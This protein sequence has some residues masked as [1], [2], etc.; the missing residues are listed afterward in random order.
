VSLFTVLLLTTAALFSGR[1]E[2]M[3]DRIQIALDRWGSRKSAAITMR[4]TPQRLS[5]A[6]RG[7]SP[8][9][10]FRLAELPD[11]FHDELDAL[12]VASRGGIVLK[13]ARLIRIVDGLEAAMAKSSHTRTI[14]L[15]LKAQVG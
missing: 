2:A 9:S 15:P 6:L 13:D 12:S 14:E 8:L 7:H 5:E 1:G 4:L 11:E 10:V 3:L